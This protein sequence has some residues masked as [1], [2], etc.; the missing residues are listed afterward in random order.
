M[1]NEIINVGVIGVGQ[2][3]KVHLE[4]YL[5]LPNVKVTAIAGR[6]PQKTEDVARQYNIPYWTT[7]FHT[8]LD[9][10]EVQAVSVCLH[11]NLHMP[12]TI[13]A[14]KAGKHVLCEKPIAG[15][16]CDGAKMLEVARQENKQLSVQISDLFSRES[17]AALSAIENGWL[18]TPYLAHSAGFR[19]RGRPYVDGYGTPSFVQKASASGGALFDM[20]IYHIANVLYLLG[21]PMPQRISGR[22][23]QRTDMDA[24]RR[25]ISNFD[26]EEVAVGLI[27]LEKDIALS[28]I[29]TWAMH[30]DSLEGSYITGTDG[31]IRLHPFGLFRSLGDMDIDA[32]ANLDGFDYRIHNVRENGDAYDNPLAHFIAAAQGRVPLIPTAEIALNTMLIS[33]GIY[34][35][36]KL[37]RE[38]TAAEVIETSVITSQEV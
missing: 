13:A 34:L 7:D 17:K 1:T 27:A 28:L 21:N 23:F 31:G 36:Q 33:E 11:N 2:I 9:K 8:L 4:G 18:G 16:Y 25:A 30:L 6:D 10:K 29:E 24:A 32:T 37:G 5:A 35:S 19:R 26:V 14:L 15:S 20:G 12:V 38:V 22:T 3:G